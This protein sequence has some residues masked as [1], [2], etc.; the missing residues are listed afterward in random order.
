[1]RMSQQDGRIKDAIEKITDD[2]NKLIQEVNKKKRAINAIY[3]T[4][5]EKAPYE[6]EGEPK[7]FQ[8]RRSQFYGKS[9]ATAVQE[10]LKIKGDACTSEEIYQSLNEGAFDF[11]WKPKDR[12][13]MVAIS[14]SRNPTV[15]HRLPNNTFGLSVWYPETQSMRKK[16]P[17]TRRKRIPKNEVLLK[18]KGTPKHIKTDSKEGSENI[19][20]DEIQG[21]KK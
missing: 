9:F 15:F 5:G 8:F 20:A 2:I 13:R 14:L 18:E 3:E 16:I 12:L 21:I 19:W 4:L 10:F 17:K 7:S 1:M 11:P 6:I